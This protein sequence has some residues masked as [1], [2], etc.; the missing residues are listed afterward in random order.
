MF[1][2]NRFQMMFAFGVVN[3]VGDK[4]SGI[5]LHVADHFLCRII[6]ILCRNLWITFLF[7]ANF[8]VLSMADD[9]AEL[10]VPVINDSVSMSFDCCESIDSVEAIERLDMF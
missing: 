6:S 3:S 1:A 8:P 2:D 4:N 5:P 9:M 10:I 7:V